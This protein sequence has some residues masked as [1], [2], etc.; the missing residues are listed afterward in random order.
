HG[1]VPFVTSSNTLAGAVSTGVGIGPKYVGHVLGVAKAYCT[2]VGEGP[3][4]TEIHGEQGDSLR[5]KGRE[6]GT[7][8]GRPRRCGWF[9]AFAMKRAVR[10]NGIDTVA[11]TKL[12]V[13]SG[14]ETIKVC[15]KYLLDGQEIDDVPSTASD[16]ARVEPVYIEVQG[17]Q[18]ELNG[19]R[20]WHHLPPAA[21]FYLSTLAEII[22]CPVS[23]V[24]VGAE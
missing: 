22:G 2:R 21:R 9:D 23:M 14:L 18:E 1:T 4:P 5:E 19:A 8:T 11:I 3:F 6:Y 13:L 10:L 7:L 17:W 24:S 12:D 20:K 15:I 16:L